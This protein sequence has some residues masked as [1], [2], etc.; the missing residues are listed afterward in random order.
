MRQEGL[1]FCTELSEKS[2]TEKGP[3]IQ[4]PTGSRRKKPCRY[5]EGKNVLGREESQ[6]RGLEALA[7]LL[8]LK[9]EEAG[10]DGGKWAEGNVGGV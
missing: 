2:F 4:R 10:F 8:C 3:F 9:N 6:G 1:P 5:L 7:Y